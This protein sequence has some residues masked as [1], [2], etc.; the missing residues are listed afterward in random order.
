M[1]YKNRMICL[2]LLNVIILTNLQVIH[3]QQDRCNGHVD[4]DLLLKV[5][6]LQLELSEYRKQA[7]E[8]ERKLAQLQ[9][10]FAEYKNDS[11]NKQT[12]LEGDLKRQGKAINGYSIIFVTI[13]YKYTSG[14]YANNVDEIV[15]IVVTKRWRPK[16]VGGMVGSMA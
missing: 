14:T 1:V 2:L 3:D 4:K 6:E 9:V 16:Y 5:R 10:E 8:T 12:A 15:W 13:Q 7:M 11:I